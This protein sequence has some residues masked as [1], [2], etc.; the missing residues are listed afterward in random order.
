[1]YIDVYYMCEYVL[2]DNYFLHQIGLCHPILNITDK[3]MMVPCVPHIL[4][5]TLR[6]LTLIHRNN[7]G[8]LLVHRNNVVKNKMTT[9]RTLIM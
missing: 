3:T 6:I 7:A 8:P 2:S 1:M 4:H 5:S 9:N